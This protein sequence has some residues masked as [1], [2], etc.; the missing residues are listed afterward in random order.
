MPYYVYVIELSDAIGPRLDPE[1]PHVYVGQSAHP[2]DVRFAQHQ[3]GYKAARSVRRFG[4]RLKPRLYQNYN[5]PAT[6][7]EALAMEA[8]LANKLRMRGYTVHGGH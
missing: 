6:R 4:T 8:R 5:P 3:A 2:P 1:K 7:E